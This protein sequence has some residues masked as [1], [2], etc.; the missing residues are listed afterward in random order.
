VRDLTPEEQSATDR[1][2]TIYTE[3][4]RSMKPRHRRSAN[5]V[6]GALFSEQ[7]QTS[8]E[9]AVSRGDTLFAAALSFQACALLRNFMGSKFGHVP[10]VTFLSSR[11]DRGDAFAGA[12]LSS[13]EELGMVGTDAS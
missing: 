3:M 10:I 7:M 6:I 1:A 4:L 2:M 8:Y 5:R 12:V 9:D 11:R 13:M